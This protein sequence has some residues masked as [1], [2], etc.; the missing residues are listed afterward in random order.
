MRRGELH[1]MLNPLVGPKRRREYELLA[2][3]L[4]K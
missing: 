3:P 1:V 4:K 2:I